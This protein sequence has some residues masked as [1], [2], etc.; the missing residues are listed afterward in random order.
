MLQQIKVRAEMYGSIEFIIKEEAVIKDD[1]VIGTG[2]Y[3]FSMKL[4]KLIPNF[5]PMQ[6]LRVKAT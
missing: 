5:I 2:S 6:G 1:E 4:S 3:V